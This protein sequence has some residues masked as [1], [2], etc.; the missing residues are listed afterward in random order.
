M[1]RATR[2][3]PNAIAV[4][5]FIPRVR[6]FVI[7]AMIVFLFLGSVRSA[8]VPL[9]TIPISLI[10]ALAAM[11]AMGFSLNLLTLLAIVLAVLALMGCGAAGNVIQFVEKFDGVSFR[12]AFELL[13]GGAGFTAPP[14]RR[15]GKL[16]APRLPPPVAFDADDV[17]LMRQVTDE[18]R[19]R[20][21]S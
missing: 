5:S 14:E 11:M 19:W 8:L 3:P 1:N 10:G 7:A 6:Q 4:R 21:A 18:A 20:F 15:T 9:V 17:A 16:S 12:H 13:A 2:H